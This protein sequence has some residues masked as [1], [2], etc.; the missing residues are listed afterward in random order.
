[1]PI[2]LDYQQATADLE[3]LFDLAQAEAPAAIK[4]RWNELIKGL[5]G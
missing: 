3:R 1:M 5:F 2:D 4:V